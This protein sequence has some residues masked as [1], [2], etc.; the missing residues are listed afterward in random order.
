MTDTNIS[1]IQDT[2]QKII[3]LLQPSGWYNKLRTFLSSEDMDK[4]LERL[5]QES[6]EERHF[7][8]TLKDVFNAFIKCPYDNTKLVILGQDPYP[9]MGVADGIAFSCSK[10]GK[11]Q[12]SLKYVFKAIETTVHQDFPTHQDV[13]LTRWADQGILCLNV[14][15]T[16]QLDKPGTHYEI[17]SD[18]MFMVIDA[19]NTKEKPVPF[20]LMGKQAQTFAPYI[21]HPIIK[22]SHP[23]SAAYAKANEWDCSDC[24][25]KANEIVK[26]HYQTKINW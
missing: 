22:A 20:I 15:L 18:F 19:L 5:L 14:A 26:E 10:T 8:P 3:K 16:C 23:A 4:L 13:D 2:K 6:K 12:P 17:W 7:T 25:N 1:I 11:V 21:T 9:Q 24:F